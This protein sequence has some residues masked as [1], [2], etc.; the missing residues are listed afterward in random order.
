LAAAAAAY[1]FVRSTAAAQ[2]SLDF[3]GQRAMSDLSYQVNLGPR[4]PNSAAHAQVV[5][6][7]QDTLGPAGWS[8]SLQKTTRLGHPIINVIAKR[9]SGT[10]WVILGAHYDSRLW[11]NQDP[12][13]ANRQK[14]VPGADDGA[15][16]VA[17]LTELARTLPKNLTGQVW[18]AFFDAEDNG[19][20][21]GWDWLLGSEEM[22]SSLPGKPDA[23]VILDMVG[24]ANLDIYKEKNSN[25]A[26]TQAIWDTAAK[27]GYEKEFIPTAKYAMLDDHTPF[28]NAGIPAV[29]IIDFDY[30]YWH[31]TQDTI[32]KTSAGSLKI[33]GETI[34]T[35]LLEEMKAKS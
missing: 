27:L 16:G 32:D 22:A 1:I 6:W 20:I 14:P 19:E 26:L 34:Q 10:P 9:G 11:A 28:L 2:Q 31:T 17:V 12:D 23:V 18:L 29:D 24:D 8:V 5:Q 33:V 15:S 25:P 30:P 21:P 4:I 13:P 7:L 35:W 3:N